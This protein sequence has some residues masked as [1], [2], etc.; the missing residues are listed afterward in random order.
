MVRAITK[1][2]PC[3]DLI[4]FDVNDKPPQKVSC[5]CGMT[6]LTEDGPE[7]SFTEPTKEELDE[8]S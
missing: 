3:L 7:G 6:K 2:N 4:W 8:I 5:R 1:C